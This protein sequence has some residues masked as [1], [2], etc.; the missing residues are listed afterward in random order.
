MIITTTGPC[1]HTRYT[2]RNAEPNLGSAV[3][4]GIFGGIFGVGVYSIKQKLSDN[5]ITAQGMIQAGSVG[6]TA[7]LIAHC[8]GSL[9]VGAIATLIIV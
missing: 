9:F 1:T 7:S 8:V 4:A 2:Y 3:V 5:E 6:F